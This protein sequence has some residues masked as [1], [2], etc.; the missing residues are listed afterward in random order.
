MGDNRVCHLD[1]NGKSLS[2]LIQKE[3]IS[4][5]LKIIGGITSGMIVKVAYWMIKGKLPKSLLLI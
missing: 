3:I 2:I 4:V 1:L 5:Q